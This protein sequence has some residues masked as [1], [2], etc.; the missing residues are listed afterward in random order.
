MERAS[1]LYK[2]DVSR[3]AEWRRSLSPD[4]ADRVRALLRV[5]SRGGPDVG[6]GL[7]KR[8][9]SSHHP[10][11]QELRPPGLNLRVLFAHDEKRDTAVMLVGG[12]KTNR[13]Q[14]WYLENVPRADHSLDLY[15]QG[16]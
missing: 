7:V 8:I 6:G 14:S 11:M 15:K 13:W 9:K 4:Q 3:I 5:L 12:D 10:E 16:Q 1:A 2:L